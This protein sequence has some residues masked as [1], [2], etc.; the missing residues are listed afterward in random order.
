ML[1]TGTENISMY[2]LITLK[3]ALKLECKG[4]K[5]SRGSA[6]AHVQKPVGFKGNQARVLE[7]LTAHRE[8]LYQAH[9][10]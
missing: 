4:L 7:Q 9:E 2:H 5:H 10:V 3:H 1:I 6:F 8:A